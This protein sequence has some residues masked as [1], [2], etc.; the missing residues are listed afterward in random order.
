MMPLSMAPEQI[1]LEVT[2]FRGGFGMRRRLAD[3]GFNIGM[4][5]SVIVNQPTG[6]MVVAIKDSRFA[7]SRG[8][9]HHIFV[10][11]K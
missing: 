5:V 9:A 2:G 3:L 11:S 1:N 8:L 4:D 6:P 7:I 10:E